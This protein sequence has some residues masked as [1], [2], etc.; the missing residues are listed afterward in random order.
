M[1]WRRHRRSSREAEQG[2]LASR[3]G[4]GV[5]GEPLEPRRLFALTTFTVDPA[6]STLRLS[7]EVASVLE[8]DEQGR[9]SLVAAYEGT[10][11]ADVDDNS[12]EFVGDS[13]IVARSKGN[14]EPG[15]APA[16]YAGESETDGLIDVRIGEAAVRGLRL[17]LTS[18]VLPLNDRGGFA[19]DVVTLRTTAGELE[20][21]LRIGGDDEIDLDN[22]AVANASPGVATLTGTGTNRTLTIPVDISFE[23]DSAELRLRGTLVAK[24][25]VGAPP[26]LNAVRVGPGGARS[27]TFTDADGTAAMVTMR[28]GLADLRFA[29]ATGQTN[30]R[31]AV[32]VQGTGVRLLGIDVQTAAGAAGSLVI[33]TLG[34]NG[35]IDLP[36]LAADGPLAALGGHGVSL[37]GTVALDGPVARLAAASL[38]GATL[39]AESIGSMTVANA[40]TDSTVTLSAPSAAGETGLR[41][42]TVRNA[43][44]GSRVSA[45]GGIGTVRAAGLV[46]SE[47]LAGTTAGAGRF[48][49]APADLPTEAPIGSLTVRS[50][51]DSVVAADN[52]GRL[53][54]GTI[55]TGNAGQ[56]FGVAGDTIQS[57][58]AAAS[59]GRQRLR[60]PLLDDPTAA[61]ALLAAQ[62]FPFGDFEIRVL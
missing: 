6:L 48:P 11:R 21:D 61:T 2:V 41:Q 3:G 50:F 28:G 29:N 39:T 57:L 42:L 20:Y 15:D 7:G 19:A 51:D 35:V 52:L 23:E 22:N 18:G 37:T 38:T 40:I 1:F 4:G 30:T 25:G 47:V 45:A 27:V 49:D 9:G 62:N 53:S 16:N 10:I 60:L 44:T 58:R 56:P 12:I 26:D 8:L 24:A 43:I 46:R 34:G 5:S 17:D 59:A 13:D 36:D 33:R 31:G 14:Y 54:L 32:A 55:D